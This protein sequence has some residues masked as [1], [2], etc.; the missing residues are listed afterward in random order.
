VN[1]RT[2][3]AALAALATLAPDEARAWDSDC[4]GCDKG[5]P[6]LVATSPWVGDSSEHS[7]LFNV[8]MQKAGIPAELQ[9]FD[10][11]VFTETDGSIIGSALDQAEFR[12]RHQRSVSEFAQLPDFGYALWDWA[13]GF[14]E[15]P[16][17][18]PFLPSYC[19]K[20]VGFMGV[21][22]SNHFLPQGQDNYAHYHGIALEV[23]A[24]CKSM[25][26]RLAGMPDSQGPMQYIGQCQQQA[27]VVEAVGQ[28]FLQDAWS[29]GHMWERWGGPE[30]DDIGADVDSVSSGAVAAAV[31]GLIHGSKSILTWDDQMSAPD[32][33]HVVEY[34]DFLGARH[35]MVGDLFMDDF[36]FE[37][38]YSAQR[39]SFLDCS[40]AGI[41]E[42]YAAMGGSPSV[43]VFDPTSDRCFGQRA[44]NLALRRG[45]NDVDLAQIVLLLGDSVN[46]VIAPELQMDLLDM[47]LRLTVAA[48]ARPYETD[49]ARGGLGPLLDVQ[50]NGAFRRSPPASYS[51]DSFGSWVASPSGAADRSNAITRVF[52]R[53]NAEAWCRAMTSGDLDNLRS[54]AVADGG[55]AA[56]DVCVEFAVR[57]IEP[58]EKEEEDDDGDGQ[59]DSPLSPT[60]VSCDDDGDG[61][62]DE[63]E[64]EE[65]EEEEEQ[66]EEEEEDEGEKYQSLCRRL[67]GGAAPVIEVEVLEEDPNEDPYQRAARWCREKPEDDEEEGVPPDIG[68]PTDECEEEEEE[69]EDPDEPNPGD[70]WGSG[71]GDPHM[72]TF[73]GLGYD[74]HASG[75][76]VLVRTPNGLFEA[77]IRTRRADDT[78]FQCDNV[79]IIDGMA[80]RL[81][82]QRFTV[83]HEGGSFLARLDGNVIGLGTRTLADGSVLT[84]KARRWYVTR[85]DGTVVYA[86]TTQSWMHVFVSPAAADRG[87]LRGLLGDGNGSIGDDLRN[88]SGTLVGSMVNGALEHTSNELYVGFLP[89][90]FVSGT[91]S[92]FDH[93]SSTPAVTYAKIGDTPSTICDYDASIAARNACRAHGVPAAWEK[94]CT[95]DVKL[96]GADMLD[97]FDDVGPATQTKNRSVCT[98][99][100][101]GDDCAVVCGGPGAP[102]CPPFP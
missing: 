100:P 63:Q 20:F 86:K 39:E 29:A 8:A 30:I 80:L 21:L 22:N 37:D 3:F 90:W 17:S 70:D 74:M 38:L 2:T 53:G 72:R 25:A 102:P 36:L 16:S 92:L 11:D 88:A 101:Y 79:G 50:V 56:L 89:T 82:A 87:L 93:T 52:H 95:L 85:P 51:D 33:L 76:F 68:Y 14:S 35:E 84:V 45:W 98:P 57:H 60:P 49:M 69:E 10:L 41:G 71:F 47:N 59:D 13:L 7:Y 75:E 66:E 77:Q 96:A 48:V 94:A 67:V 81:G 27:L 4:G 31:A 18:V 91:A 24:Q 73:D 1:A 6:E 99:T 62:D 5:P 54:R 44:T 19:H 43:P 58:K 40:A 23:A 83:Q 28:H 42:V 9:G 64:E 46:V 34:I 15:C 55:G 26:D 65:E 61:E 78:P 32:P 97:A 12:S